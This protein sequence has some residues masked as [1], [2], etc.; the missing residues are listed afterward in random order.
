MPAESTRVDIFAGVAV[1]L[2]TT[3]PL[4]KFIQMLIKV[5]MLPLAHTSASPMIC[6]SAHAAARSQ[7]HSLR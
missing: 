5:R 3:A 6:Y 4:H 7:L 2:S 1:I